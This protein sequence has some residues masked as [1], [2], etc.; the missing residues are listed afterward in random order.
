AEQLKGHGLDAYWTRASGT[1]K[2][3]YQVRISHYATKEAAR[4]IGEEL[5]G[6]QLIAD[7]YVA[8]YKRPEVP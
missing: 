5:K 6:R 1:N 3:W 4:A 7:Y 8:N 2:T